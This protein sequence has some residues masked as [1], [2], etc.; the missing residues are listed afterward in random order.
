M[1][2]PLVC[3]WWRGHVK[4]HGMSVAIFRRDR[5]SFWGLYL[6][7][8]HWLSVPAAYFKQ[9][10]CECLIKTVPPARNT[11]ANLIA[12]TLFITILTIVEGWIIFI[13]AILR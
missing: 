5:T 4:E 2:S 1:L 7:K 9:D 11:L 13:D 12:W 10:V 8:L 6:S 3:L